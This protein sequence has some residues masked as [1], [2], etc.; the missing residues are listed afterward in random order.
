AVEPNPW[1]VAARAAALAL[2]SETPGDED[3]EVL[4]V[5]P[6][7]GAMQPAA[8]TPTPAPQMPALPSRPAGTGGLAPPAHVPTSGPG[9][10]YGSA[11]LTPTERQWVAPGMIAR[12]TISLASNTRGFW[13]ASILVDPPQL[14]VALDAGG[15]PMDCESS[16]GLI[17]C[18]HIPGS[19]THMQLVA[20]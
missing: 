4:M 1:V 9:A 14:T 11:S 20:V 5:T 16:T 13:Q 7:T 19:T 3:D 2:P 8:Q 6:T 15:T 10:G 12:W 18:L 17:T